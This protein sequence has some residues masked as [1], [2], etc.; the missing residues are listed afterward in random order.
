VKSLLADAAG[1]SIHGN[2]VAT[3]GL[4]LIAAAVAS[5]GQPAAEG[6]LLTSSTFMVMALAAANF[7]AGLPIA[8]GVAFHERPTF[9]TIIVPCDDVV[10]ITCLVTAHGAIATVAIAGILDLA[11]V[12]IVSTVANT[13]VGHSLVEAVVFFMMLVMFVVLV[14]MSNLTAR[15]LVV[16]VFL[17]VIG[18]GLVVVALVSLL[19]PFMFAVALALMA[20]AFARVGQPRA[21][22]TLAL[23]I[24]AD[25][26]RRCRGT[27][28]QAA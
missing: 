17:I 3:A 12:V 11:L 25:G 5:G 8:A 6:A 7:L 10:P 27:K 19:F 26:T 23:T 20:A 9:D 24:A 15:P 21:E 14:G 4:A 13:G 16:L 28:G 2:V 22:A 1:V 18:L